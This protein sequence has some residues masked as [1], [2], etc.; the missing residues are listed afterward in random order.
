MSVES[1]LATV[2]RMVQWAIRDINTLIARVDMSDPDAARDALQAELPTLISVWGEAAATVA[3]EYFEELIDAPAVLADPVDSE[4]VEGMVGWAVGPLYGE[5]VPRVDENGEP[6]LD[7]S[8]EPVVDKIPPDPAKAAR[9]LQGAS[10]R[11]ILNTGRD[12]IRYSAENTPGVGWARILQGETNCAFCVTIASRGAVFESAQTA[13]AQS[14]G[15][16]RIALGDRYHSHCVLPGAMVS[17]PPVEAAMRRD[18]EGE[19]VT[20]VT[21]GGRDLTVTPNHPILTDRG[22]VPAQFINEGDNLVGGARVSGSVVG[23][24]DE[25]HGPARIEDFV[26]AFGV[27]SPA[28]FGGVPTSA[29]EFHGD[30]GNSEVN[31]VTAHDLLGLEADAALRKP[32]P[33]LEFEVAGAMRPVGDL[34]RDRV[35]AREPGFVSVGGSPDGVMGGSGLSLP[36]CGTHLARAVEAGGGS[37]AGLNPSVDEGSPDDTPADSGVLE[38]GVLGFA[39]AVPLNDSVRDVV[40]SAVMVR[41]GR[42]FDP[43]LLY[44]DPEGLAVYS[45]LGSDLAERLAGGVELDRVVD[46]SV[47]VYHGTVYNLSTVEGWYS[48]NDI[49]TS[50]C[51][52]QVIPIRDERDYPADYDVDGLYDMYMAARRNAD[53]KVLKGGENNIL[54]QMRKMYGMK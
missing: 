14:V 1:Y 3:A 26:S 38:D 9:N 10:Q 52:C 36:L 6:V 39:V 41:V 21:S 8:G 23:G 42:K 2:Q 28:L 24:P 30:G 22:W 5:L 49:I 37:V 31:V 13:G 29:E 19:V 34:G 33:E 11:H 7:G 4:V 45:K 40:D 44:G 20:L 46:K 18:Y 48:V 17:G 54:M 12:T 35:G 50:N 43:P 32:L 16:D 51:D 25:D 27:V 47:S 15:D 53:D